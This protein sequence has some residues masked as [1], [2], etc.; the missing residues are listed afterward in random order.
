MNN[1]TTSTIYT[2]RAVDI[3]CNYN[4]KVVLPVQVHSYSTSSNTPEVNT[5]SVSIVILWMMYIEIVGISVC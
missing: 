1:D 5:I 3:G 2:I 4:F